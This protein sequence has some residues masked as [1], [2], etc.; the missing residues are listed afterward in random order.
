MRVHS[1]WFASAVLVLVLGS[2]ETPT[3]DTDAA[4]K[5]LIVQGWWEQDGAGE[6]DA[7]EMTVRFWSDGTA[8]RNGTT[9]DT[10][11]T[12]KSGVFTITDP[13]G[14][15]STTDPVITSSQFTFSCDGGTAYLVPKDLTE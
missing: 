7:V 11:W 15:Y 12:Y 9:G 1:S 8:S 3:T 5:A 2:C 10:T 6:T 13:L 14:T 4:T